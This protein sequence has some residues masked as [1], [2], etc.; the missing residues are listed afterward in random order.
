MPL[1]LSHDNN[2]V[3]SSIPPQG[4]PELNADEKEYKSYTYTAN[5]LDN[6]MKETVQKKMRAAKSNAKLTILELVCS[7]QQ[8]DSDDNV[9]DDSADRS[10]TGEDLDSNDSDDND[11]V[12]LS[13]IQWGKD[14][15][16]RAT[17]QKKKKISKINCKDNGK[18]HSSEIF[19]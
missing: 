7:K 15:M 11:D 2:V 19:C 8:P 1:Q 16:E 9:D 13:F 4:H 5:D 3:A 17:A 18:F 10:Y 14:K 6:Y 12:P